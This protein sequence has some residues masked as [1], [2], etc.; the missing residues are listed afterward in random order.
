MTSSNH[1]VPSNH[2][3]QTMVAIGDVDFCSLATEDQ[4]NLLI[5]QWNILKYD[6]MVETFIIS[7]F[8]YAFNYIL[9]IFYELHTYSLK[10]HKYMV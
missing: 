7:H 4:H 9:S 10:L 6:L 2:L 1:D 3:T 8:N 5:M